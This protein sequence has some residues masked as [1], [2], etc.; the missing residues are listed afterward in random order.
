MVTGVEITSGLTPE[1]SVVFWETLFTPSVYYFGDQV[2][3]LRSSSKFCS[4]EST[5]HSLFLHFTVLSL[6]YSTLL[7]F[8]VAQRLKA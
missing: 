5:I 2:W 8:H 4:I 6:Y 7:H 3:D 1:F